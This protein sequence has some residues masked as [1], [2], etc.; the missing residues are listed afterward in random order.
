MSMTRSHLGSRP[1]EIDAEVR[2]IVYMGN[3]GSNMSNVAQG[4]GVVT[5]VSRGR[6][7]LEVKV[8]ELIL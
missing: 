3:D 8:V 4:G 1:I 2:C 5:I 7:F 6:S